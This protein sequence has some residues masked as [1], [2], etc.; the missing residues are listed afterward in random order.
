M[1]QYPAP[2]GAPGAPAASRSSCSGPGEVRRVLP[3]GVVQIRL[4]SGE[5]VSAQL[6]AVGYTDPREGDRVLAWV[7]DAGR[8]FVIGVLPRAT[9]LLEKALEAEERD[10]TVKVHDRAGRLLFEYDP[11]RDRAVLHAPSGDL[12]L[13]V[14]NGE[15]SLRARD[16]VKLE[17]PGDVSIQGGRSVNLEASRENGPRARIAMQP[18]ELSFVSS[19]LTAA[20]DRAEILASKIGARAHFFESHIDRVRQ[21]VKVL[22]VRAG[23]IVEHAK[24]VYRETEGLS[25]TRAGRLRMVAQKAVQIVGETALVK[26][27]DRVK[28]RGE[29][30]HLN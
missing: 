24:D 14:P 19:V 28:I 15:L 10:P 3:S 30:I 25:Q 17:T 5:E 26:G 8:A 22:D 21:V 9:S 13:S 11:E 23:R 27:R 1:K 20:A 7:D 18:G 16:G 6:A 12:E 2:E 29:R 4:E